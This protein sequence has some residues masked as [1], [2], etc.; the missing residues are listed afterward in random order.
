MIVNIEEKLN[1]ILKTT[2][3]PNFLISPLIPKYDDNCGNAFL[4]SNYLLTMFAEPRIYPTYYG[5]LT[6]TESD[7]CSR[8]VSKAF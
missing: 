6:T 2:Q 1:V 5:H 8:L 4:Q 7:N 3:Y